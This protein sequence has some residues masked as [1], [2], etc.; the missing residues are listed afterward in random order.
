ME[1]NV[2]LTPNQRKK[3]KTCFTNKTE[4]TLRIEPKVGNNKFKLTAT[5]IQKLKTARAK[6]KLF[7]IKLSKTQLQKSGG[8]LPFLIPLATLQSLM[9]WG[10]VAGILC[11]KLE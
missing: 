10:T 4:C 5:Q 3:L 8:F 1:Y 7:D 2:Y 6:N 11:L 9:K